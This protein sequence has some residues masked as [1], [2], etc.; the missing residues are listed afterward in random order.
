MVQVDMGYTKQAGVIFEMNNCTDPKWRVFEIIE[1]L[2]GKDIEYC[3]T[4]PVEV[5][6]DGEIL[7]KEMCSRFGD[8][9]PGLFLRSKL[10]QVVQKG[11]SHRI[12][13]GTGKMY[14]GEVISFFGKSRGIIICFSGSFGQ[15]PRFNMKGS[16]L[17]K[18]F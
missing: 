4:L 2:R 3:D 17:A 8:N 9:E 15:G 6:K 13:C 12:I 10:Y 14:G 7:C 16:G 1:G 5:D 18:Q 11:G